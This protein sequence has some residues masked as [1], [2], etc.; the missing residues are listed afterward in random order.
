MSG[1]RNFP[2]HLDDFDQAKQAYVSY[3]MLGEGH[4]LFQHTPTG[5]IATK[6]PLAG[7]ISA[8]IAAPWSSTSPEGSAGVPVWFW[9][10]AWRL[11]GFACAILLL[12]CV[13]RVGS[14]LG[15]EVGAIVAVGALGLNLMAPRLAT[16]VRTDQMLAFLI[17]IT[18]WTVWNHVRHGGAWTAKERWTIFFSLLAS[19]LV[20]GPI[21]YAFLLPGIVAYWYLQRNSAEPGQVWSGAWSWFGPLAI[22]AAWAA[23]GIFSSSEFYEEVFLREFLGRFTVG[24]GAVHHNQPLWFYLANILHKFFPWSL[25]LILA[26][27]LPEVRSRIRRDPELLWLA[28]WALGGIAFMSCVPSKRADRIF[29]VIPPLCILLAACLPLIPRGRLRWPLT[30]IALWA[31]IFAI[32]NAGGYTVLKMV[33]GIRDHDEALVVFGERV[34]KLGSADRLAVLNGKDEGM[35]IYTNV[36]K[37]TS[38]DDAVALWDEGKIDRVVIP[39]SARRAKKTPPIR[40][41]FKGAEDAFSS[42]PAP[43]KNSRYECLVRISSDSLPALE[44]RREGGN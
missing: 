40:N 35:L 6:P 36:R 9:Q 19:M 27:A 20:K 30:K 10:V 38:L 15:G 12:I 8:A 2:W 7:W 14:R 22:F 32:V 16:L 17:F 41:L 5:R 34:R 11:P 3:E 21:A 23:Y 33:D 43:E 28:C 18:G 39:A 29:P 37:F 44:D 24:E 13:Y 42:V 31:V 1:A 26:A 25:G 4:W